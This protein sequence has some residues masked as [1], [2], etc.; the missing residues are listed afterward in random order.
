[1]GRTARSSLNVPWRIEV[2]TVQVYTLAQPI[3]MSITNHTP[4][5]LRPSSYELPCIS[6]T[7]TAVTTVHQVARPT[8]PTP[9][10]SPSTSITHT[11]TQPCV[12][13][14]STTTQTLAPGSRGEAAAP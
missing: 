11:D 3:L 10:T 1:M 4:L 6:Q 5:S 14:Y 2:C 8:S 12:S 9:H 7:T 13:H